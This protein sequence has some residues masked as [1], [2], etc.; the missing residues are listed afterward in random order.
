[1]PLCLNTSIIRFTPK[2]SFNH[3]SLGS[4]AEWFYEYV[5]GIKPLEAGFKRLK[6]QPF[7]DKTGNIK[8]ATGEFCSVL[9]NISV[10]WEKQ[11]KGYFCEIVKSADMETQFVF[12][13][14]TKILCDG[15]ETKNFMPFA[16]VTQVYFGE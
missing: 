3:Y 16:K 5:L 8:S 13:K 7:V 6:I 11:E 4:C 2:H 15:E 12:E 10:H 9:G 1:M 14:V